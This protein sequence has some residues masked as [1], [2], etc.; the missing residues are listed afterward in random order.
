MTSYCVSLAH[1]MSLSSSKCVKHSWKNS[2]QMLPFT[3]FPIFFYCTIH[4][5]SCQR[6][7]S[8]NFFWND[9]CT[10]QVQSGMINVYS[11]LPYCLKKQGCYLNLNKRGV[12]SLKT[13]KCNWKG[14]CIPRSGRHQWDAKVVREAFIN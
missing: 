11:S 1:I 7:T 13:V 3:Y 10:I 12:T 2:Q 14:N 5:C 9:C 6:P 4:K 8:Q